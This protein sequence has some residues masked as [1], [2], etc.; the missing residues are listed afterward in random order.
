MHVMKKLGRKNIIF[1]V[2]VIMV[3]LIGVA[4]A[5]FLSNLNNTKTQPV[6]KNKTDTPKKLPAEKKADAADKLAYQGDVKAGTQA[7][8]E[9]IRGTTDSYEQFVYYSR[10]ATLLLNHNDTAGALVAAK[11]AYELQKTADSA[12]FVGQISRTRGEASEALTYYKRAIELIDKTSP[13]AKRDSA[14]YAR[15]VAELGGKV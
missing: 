7:L 14:Y 1:V 13:M 11:K 6:D 12:A 5:I 10:K 8:D 9:A 4:S 15:V 2:I 3:V